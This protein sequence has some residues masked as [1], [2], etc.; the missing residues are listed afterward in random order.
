MRELKDLVDCARRAASRAA[1]DLV[2]AH[3]PAP[4]AWT[5]KGPHDFVTEADRRA[6]ALIAETLTA[7]AP[8]SVV[9]G[10]ELS[11]TA[12]RVGTG[13][14]D[15]VWI[16]D[17]LDGTTNFLHGYPQY[18]VSIGCVAGGAFVAGNPQMHEWLSTL[19]RSSERGSRNAEP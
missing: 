8:G 2:A 14:A 1:T 6:E 4:S 18:A 13:E 3:V 11:P 5:E 9:I 19:L 12:A 7:L 15:L 10:E 16:V 17:P